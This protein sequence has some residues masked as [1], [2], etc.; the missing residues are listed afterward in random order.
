[1]LEAV[2]TICDGETWNTCAL[3]KP[4][5]LQRLMEEKLQTLGVC[6]MLTLHSF[7]IRQDCHYT[8]PYLPCYCFG[9]LF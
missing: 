8:L 1:L 7:P 5:S 9:S 3:I 2:L 6:R 4:F